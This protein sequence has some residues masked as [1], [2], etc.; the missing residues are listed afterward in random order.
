MIIIPTTSTQVPSIQYAVNV[1]VTDD[2]YVS[3]LI[4]VTIILLILVIVAKFSRFYK[5]LRTGRVESYESV[6]L[7]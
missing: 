7:L 3:T 2:S 1:T 5:I 6:P 4:C